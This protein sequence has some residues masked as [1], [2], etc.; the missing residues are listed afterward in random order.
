MSVPPPF[1]SPQEAAAARRQALEPELNRLRE[2]V[3]ETLAGEPY[4]GSY[5]FYP[6][7]G[8][9]PKAVEIVMSE[10]APG[11]QVRYA[12][13]QREGNFWMITPKA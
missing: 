13:D 2:A 3:R 7:K 8:S 10:L 5:A 6:P 9:T 4:Q 12:T 1:P 11:W